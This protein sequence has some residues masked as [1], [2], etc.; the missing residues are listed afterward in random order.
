MFE[1]D[2][3]TSDANELSRRNSRAEKMSQMGKNFMRQVNEPGSSRNGKE[4]DGGRSKQKKKIRSRKDDESVAEG[5]K[6]S[7]RFKGAGSSEYSH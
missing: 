5:S 7:G 1:D 3:E 2:E 6:Y 4:G